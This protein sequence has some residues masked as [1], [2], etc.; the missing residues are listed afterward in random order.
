MAGMGVGILCLSNRYV[1]THHPQELARGLLP[2]WAACRDA[3]RDESF[4]AKMT[5]QGKF[6]IAVTEDL[7]QACLQS[8]FV[9]MYGGSVTQYLFIVFALLKAL[10]CLL[11]RATIMER[12]ARFRDAYEAM[13]LYYELVRYVASTLGGRHSDFALRNQCN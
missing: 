4:L 1:R 7:P 3:R 13:V 9:L 8:L 2:V 11:L 12:E 6:A 10:A 5:S